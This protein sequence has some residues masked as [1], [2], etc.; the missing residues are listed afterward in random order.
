MFLRSIW[1]HRLCAY[2]RHIA[3]A[4]AGLVTAVFVLHDLAEQMPLAGLVQSPFW[5]LRVIVGVFA[6]ASVG[7]VFPGLILLAP[8]LAGLASRWNAPSLEAGDEV[9]VL[10]GPLRGLRTTVAEMQAGQGGGRLAVLREDVPAG[11]DGGRCFEM[12]QVLKC[13]RVFLGKPD[14]ST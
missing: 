2:P 4:G 9:I 6:F 13:N 1:L 5:L 8:W 14:F 10:R 7:A 12:Y 11:S 3:A